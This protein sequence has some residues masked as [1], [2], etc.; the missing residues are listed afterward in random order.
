MT[1]YHSHT[2]PAP[3]HNEYTSGE[4]SSG[5][6]AGDCRRSGP[7]TSA[8]DPFPYSSPQSNEVPEPRTIGTPL[9]AP[10]TPNYESVVEGL[11]VLGH[12]IPRQGSTSGG[13]EICLIVKNLPPTVELYARFG[14][15]IVATV[16]CLMISSLIEPNKCTDNSSLVSYCTRCTHLPSPSSALPRPRRRHI[17]SDAFC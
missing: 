16:S 17:A 1:F 3:R 7:S 14:Y 13:E 15:N 10:A 4:G 2:A 6:S 12:V 8:Q 5:T 9:Q 11:V